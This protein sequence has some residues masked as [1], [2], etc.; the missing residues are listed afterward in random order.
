MF[1]TAR[2][3]LALR[4]WCLIC[5]CLIRAGGASDGQQRHRQDS[6]QEVQF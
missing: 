6:S 2:A 5:V 1:R 4:H 3:V